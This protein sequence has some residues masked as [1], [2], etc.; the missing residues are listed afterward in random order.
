MRATLAAFR[1]IPA[2]SITLRDARTKT[3]RRAELQEFGMAR[4]PVTWTQYTAVLNRRVPARQDPHAPV[5]SV[6]W[7]EAIQWCNTASVARG[8]AP[9]YEFDGA[10]VHWRVDANGFR[11]PTE[12]EWEWACRAGTTGPTYGPLEQIA[13]TALDGTACAQPVGAKAPNAFDLHDILGNVWE[14]CWDYADT[15]RYADYRVLR[16]GGWADK[17]WSVRASVRRASMPATV[18]DDVGFRLAQGTVGSAGATQA[19]GWSHE[20]DVRRAAL[21]P[22]PSGWTPLNFTEP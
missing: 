21:S 8:L 2:G 7:R 10:Y 6:S 12:A 20:A 11:L 13:W 17:P 1:A 18:L 16:G 9:A 15:A 3:T 19:Q 5:H 22:L 14:W 4:T